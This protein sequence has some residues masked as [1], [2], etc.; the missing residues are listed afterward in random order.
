MRTNDHEF[1]GDSVAKTCREHL[2][3]LKQLGIDALVT[4]THQRHDFVARA[5]KPKFQFF[6]NFDTEVAS[7]GTPMNNWCYGEESSVGETMHV[8]ESGHANT[9]HRLVIAKRTL[10]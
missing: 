6:G 8:A 3:L 5:W 2:I 4:G 7:S 9:I 10:A 1:D